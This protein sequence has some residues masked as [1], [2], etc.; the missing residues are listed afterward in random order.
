MPGSGDFV[1][2]WTLGVEFCTDKLSSEWGF[3]RKKLVAPGLAG[4][5]GGMVTGQIDTCIIFM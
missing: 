3:W 1:L 4:G 2:F 5:G